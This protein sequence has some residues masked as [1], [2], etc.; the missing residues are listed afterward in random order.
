MTTVTVSYRVARPSLLRATLH[1]L[2]GCIVPAGIHVAVHAVDSDPDFPFDSALCG[3]PY[4]TDGMLLSAGP[5][6]S[7]PASVNV[8]AVV[9]VVI[10]RPDWDAHFAENMPAHFLFMAAAHVRREVQ[11]AWRLL[12]QRIVHDPYWIAAHTPAGAD[13]VARVADGAGGVSRAAA[14]HLHN[15]LVGA[16]V[17]ECTDADGT[18]AA[19]LARLASGRCADGLAPDARVAAAR[20]LHAVG[21]PPVRPATA[22]ATTYW[23]ALL[24]HVAAG[25]SASRPAVVYSAARVGDGVCARVDVSSMGFAVA[26]PYPIIADAR[27]AA[28]RLAVAF[29]Q[30]YDA[31]S[32][33][34]AGAKQS[35]GDAGDIGA[36][37]GGPAVKSS[38]TAAYPYMA[39]L[40]AFCRACRVQSP[41]YTVEVLDANLGFFASVQVVTANEA[42]GVAGDRIT[43]VFQ[44]PAK[45]GLHKKSIAKEEAARVACE[46]LGVHVLPTPEAAKKSVPVQSVPARKQTDHHVQN[47]RVIHALPPRP[48]F[49]DTL[50]QKLSIEPGNTSPS[51]KRTKID[52]D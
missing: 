40:A 44:A 50:S 32:A 47:K 23:T 3:L 7:P 21:S 14:M 46:S 31:S 18:P 45:A 27:D 5:M 38:A 10:D 43:R 24:Q 37:S 2:R 9:R 4:Q 35:G 33:I 20:L 48:S 13:L 39:A 8:D 42:V 16:R 41:V 12:L 28:A 30:R 1:L 52:K 49:S 22:A 15:M 6:P 26:E 19:V 29:L 17:L 34:C 25:G 36:S 51:T 11:R